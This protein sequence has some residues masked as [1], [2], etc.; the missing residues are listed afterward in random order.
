[1]DERPKGYA[2]LDRRSSLVAEQP[3]PH[4]DPVKPLERPSLRR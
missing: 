2:T 4:R 1:V 3:C